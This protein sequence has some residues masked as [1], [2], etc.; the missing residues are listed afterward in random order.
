[1]PQVDTGT[2]DLGAT[3]FPFASIGEA[4]GNVFPAGADYK[5]ELKMPMSRC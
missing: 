3:T 4:G 1:M 5:K 2:E